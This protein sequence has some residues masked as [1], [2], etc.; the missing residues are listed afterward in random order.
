[1]RIKMPTIDELNRDEYTPE[2]FKLIE[3]FIK[4]KG[5]LQTEMHELYKIPEDVCMDFCN[6]I[7]QVSDNIINKYANGDEKNRIIFTYFY[8]E[9]VEFLNKHMKLQQE[10][11]DKLKG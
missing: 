8:R 6:E 10:A 1:M 4:D 3:Y 5:K 9:I 11:E 2:K 7:L